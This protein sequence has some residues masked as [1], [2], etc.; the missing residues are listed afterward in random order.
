MGFD[1]NNGYDDAYADLS[2]YTNGGSVSLTPPGTTCSGSDS[3]IGCDNNIATNLHGGCNDFGPPCS[4]GTGT[5]NCLETGTD[6]YRLNGQSNTTSIFWVGDFCNTGQNA[7]EGYPVVDVMDSTFQNNYIRN[8]GDG[9]PRITV[10]SEQPT[11]DPNTSD[12]YA[13]IYNYATS[14]WDQVYEGTGN[15]LSSNAGLQ[16]GSNGFIGW[17]LDEYDY[18]SPTL[19]GCPMVPDASADDIQVADESTGNDQNN[20]WRG[21][22]FSDYSVHTPQGGCFVD[23]GSGNGYVYSFGQYT[24]A[25]GYPAWEVTDPQPAKCS[26]D[27]H[28][29]CAILQSSVETSSC[30]TGIKGPHGSDIYTYAHKL[31]YDIDEM[32]G[33]T[34]TFKEVAVETQSIPPKAP[35]TITATYSPNNPA[36]HYGDP[37]LP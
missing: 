13:F 35:C 5:G 11:T 17:T 29:Y 22:G 28:G 4:L 25:Q 33:G 37:N 23:D 3:G 24:D 15:F 32:I 8:F 18:E 27:S 2:A 1:I 30:D 16:A 9:I 6:F 19:I 36:V 10:E 31:S 34:S 14:Q 20:Y 21:L 12:W 26:M 7:F